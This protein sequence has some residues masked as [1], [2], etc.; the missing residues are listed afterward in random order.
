MSA[1]N[2]VLVRSVPTKF[3]QPGDLFVEMP[4]DA[5]GNKNARL[6]AHTLEFGSIFTPGRYELAI[7]YS[8]PMQMWLPGV[9][10]PARRKDE[11][12]GEQLGFI[13]PGTPHHMACRHIM[14]GNER[15]LDMV[16]DSRRAF[17]EF[18]DL[19]DDARVNFDEKVFL[20]I[21]A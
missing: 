4:P 15:R 21:R 6:Q 1:L 3:T 19:I 13:H 5:A 18:Y 2:F 14:L 11:S 9:F 10:A 8:S 7:V 16:I 12:L 17:K 20:E